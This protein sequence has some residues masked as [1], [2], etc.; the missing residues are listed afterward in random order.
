MQGSLQPASVPCATVAAAF[1]A[2]R[3]IDLC[4]MHRKSDDEVAAQLQQ[5]A[6]VLP[7]VTSLQLGGLWSVK[8]GTYNAMSMRTAGVTKWTG[9]HRAAH[10]T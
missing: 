1:S 8:L 10:M 3:Q 9:H 4:R 2:V 7:G 6:L 5:L